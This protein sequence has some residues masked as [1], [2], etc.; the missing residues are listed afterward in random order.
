M[1]TKTKKVK[2]QIVETPTPT[3]SSSPEQIVPVQKI[4]YRNKLISQIG[5]EAVRL[6]EKEMRAAAKLRKQAVA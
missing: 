6:K 5:I 3:P 4:S 2:T 1:S